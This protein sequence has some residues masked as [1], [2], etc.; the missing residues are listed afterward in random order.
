ETRRRLER[1]LHDGAQQR[2]VAVSIALRQAVAALLSSPE[3]AGA[4]LVGA[5]DELTEALEELRDLAR[6]LHPA[7]LAKYGLGPAL[8]ALASRVPLPVVVENDIDDR[9]PAPVEAALYY[10]VS[11]SLTNVAKH[12]GA[13]TV[14]V[15][16]R[17]ADSV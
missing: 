10:V 3:Q 7:T 2:L 15:G 16:I 13:S 1:N 17:H 14:T 9:L 6:G 5:S 4:L 11:E 8:D 12:A